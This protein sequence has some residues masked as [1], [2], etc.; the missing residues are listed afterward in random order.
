MASIYHTLCTLAAVAN[1]V[2]TAQKAALVKLPLETIQS[3]NNN[4]IEKETDKLG[5]FVRQKMQYLTNKLG[6]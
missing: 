4:V 3:L 5:F 2:I 6:G 1:G